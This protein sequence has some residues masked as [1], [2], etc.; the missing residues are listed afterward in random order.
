VADVVCDLSPSGVLL[1]TLNRPDRMNTLGGTIVADFAAA[2]SEATMNPAV[3][4][5]AIT[6]AGK[7][8][9]AGAELVG[10]PSGAQP[11][12]QPPKSGYLSTVNGMDL[13]HDRWAGAAWACPKPTIGL[14][15]GAAAGAGMGLAL[16]LDFRIAARS[17]RFVSAFARV[18]LSGDNGV[19]YALSHLMGRSKALEILMLSPRIDAQEALELGLVR[20]VVADDELLARGMDFAER[21]AK[22]PTTIYA[23]M[24]RNLAFAETATFEQALERE[25]SGIA[26]SQTSGDFRAAATAFLEK[27]EPSFD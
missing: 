7:A 9:C 19:T 10:A 15:N 2:M 17:A 20:E 3:R 26:I 23:L 12:G 22:G 1:V 11:P 21:L 4:T 24:K 14:I 18:A 27:R 25:G 8:F 16:T 13:I 5:V 6:G